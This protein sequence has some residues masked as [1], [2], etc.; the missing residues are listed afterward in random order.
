MFAIPLLRH[1][2][3]KKEQSTANKVEKNPM[4][5]VRIELGPP[6]YKSNALPLSQESTPLRSCQRL[7]INL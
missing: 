4:T 2:S 5:M 7:N 6:G 1:E 3:R